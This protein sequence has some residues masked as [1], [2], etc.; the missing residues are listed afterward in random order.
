MVDARGGGDRDFMLLLDITIV[1]ATGVAIF[2]AGSL[3][4]GALISGPS[5]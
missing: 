2:A 1:F 4:C 3:L 5:R